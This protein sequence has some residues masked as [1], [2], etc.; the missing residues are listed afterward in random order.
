MTVLAPPNVVR[1]TEI[2]GIFA[3]SILVIDGLRN[4]FSK[5]QKDL[6]KLGDPIG[7]FLLDK[8]QT[9]I[10]VLQIAFTGF[11]LWQFLKLTDNVRENYNQLSQAQQQGPSV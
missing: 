6:R 4:I 1:T 9:L 8:A 2:A 5:P 11:G 3:A 7:A 10:G